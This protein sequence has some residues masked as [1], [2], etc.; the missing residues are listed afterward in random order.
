M[1]DEIEHPT[2]S[3]AL[4]RERS[5]RKI[6][7]STI[8]KKDSELERL[9]KEIEKLRKKNE[10]LENENE[11]LK[12]ELAGKKAKKA[13]WVKTNKPED[14]KP[15]KKLGPKKGHKA[16]K[17][18]IPEKIDREV[19][20][21]PEF[22][23]NC[24]SEVSLPTRWHTHT[25]VDIPLNRK[26][27]TTQYNVGWCYCSHC[28]KEVSH[29]AKLSNSKYGPNL[30]ALI[31]DQK[32]NLGLTL[33]K[34]AKG[35]KNQYGL[36]LSTGQISEIL[37]RGGREFNETYEDLKA[38]LPDEAHLHAD[39]TGWRVS[40]KNHWLWSFS[41]ER[42]SVYTI[43]K[44]RA[45]KVVEE[46]LGKSFD[47]ILVS[48]FYG[49]YNKLKARKQKCWTH[50]LRELRELKGAFPHNDEILSYSK[51]LKIFFKRSIKL[52]VEFNEG[53]KI[54]KQFNRLF[55]DTLRF[56][57]HNWRHEDLRR[58]S[59]RVQK[60]RSELYVFIKENISPTN[61]D[62][63]REVRPA[64]LMRKTSYGNRSDDGADT[65][66]KMMS[67]IRT[68][69]KQNESFLHLAAQHLSYN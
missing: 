62:A 48:D 17:R 14:G 11:K 39:E 21:R 64:V 6:L 57:A 4:L 38:M 28:E 30:H 68:C 66:A 13:S 33:G 52:Q 67:V 31:L 26:T 5:K 23:P 16:N 8:N 27:I 37:S 46:H 63:E 35:L 51:Q 7:E 29:K 58:I 3:K 36:L 40:G 1:T 54:E 15:G 45:Q 59:K 43:A 10:K 49:A 42:I 69:E 60:Y 47:G 9:K 32:F 34:I 65:Q 12:Q 55:D 20:L 50:L 61:N 56:A 44:S 22:C 53:K 41:N 18:T 24:E 19:V 2:K 25:Q